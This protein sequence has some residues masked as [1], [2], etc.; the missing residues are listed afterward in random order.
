LKFGFHDCLKN[1]ADSCHIHVPKER[2]N[3]VV[4]RG[5][6]WLHAVSSDD[7]LLYKARIGNM[8][9]EAVRWQQL[10]ATALRQLC[11]ATSERE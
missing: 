8:D 11:S 2:Q 1:I 7:A 9:D 4:A 10:A 6:N 5:N 3:N